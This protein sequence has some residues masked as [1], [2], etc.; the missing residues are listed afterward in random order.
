[1]KKI[2]KSSMNLVK[3]LFLGEEKPRFRRSTV[4]WTVQ[5]SNM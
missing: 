1:M 4:W 5:D 3:N 2:Q